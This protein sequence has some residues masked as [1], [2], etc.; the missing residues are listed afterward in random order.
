MKAPNGMRSGSLADELSQ[1]SGNLIADLPEYHGLLVYRGG[2]RVLEAMVEPCA[3]TGEN[4][5]RL[6]RVSHTV[7]TQS[8]C[9]PANSST[10]FER[11]PAMSIPIS[12]IAV[13][14][15]GLRPTGRI[16]ALNTSN[17]SPAI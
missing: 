7:K 9:C 17:L 16:P 1:S 11:L 5:A 3:C 14:A 6:L 4:G 10:D 2:C 15:F 8:N 13:T 12:A